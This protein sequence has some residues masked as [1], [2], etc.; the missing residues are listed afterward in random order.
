MGIRRYYFLVLLLVPILISI[1]SLVFGQELSIDELLLKGDNYYF[2]GKYQEALD[3]YSQAVD[4]DPK[5]DDA[6]YFAGDSL[7]MLKRYEEAISKFDQSIKINPASDAFFLKGKSHYMLEKY[8]EA[9]QNYEYSLDIFPDEPYVLAHY[10]IA[11]QKVGNTQKANETFIEANKLS[12]KIVELVA[13]E[14][15]Y[16]LTIKYDRLSVGPGGISISTERVKYQPFQAVSISGYV[17][18][19]SGNAYEDPKKVLI[20][21]YYT[22]NDKRADVKLVDESTVFSTY[23]YDVYEDPVSYYE[24]G[25]AV[26]EEGTYL[27][28]ATIDAY[29]SLEEIASTQIVVS[30]LAYSPV[31]V[32]LGIGVAGLGGLLFLIAKGLSI[33]PMI[34]ESLRFACITTIAVVPIGVFLTVD[35][36]VGQQSPLGLVIILNDNFVSEW[37]INIGG[38]WSD[39]YSGGIQI[40]VFVLLFGIAGGYIR[41]LHTIY[42]TLQTDETSW[43][44]SLKIVSDVLLKDI[45]RTLKNLENSEK[46]EDNTKIYK[47]LNKKLQLFQDEDSKLEEIRR[48]IFTQSIKDLALLFL[49]ALLAI[50]S[51]F[52]LIQAGIQSSDYATIAAVS[53]G[54]GLAT[55]TV[56]SRL[57]NFVGVAIGKEK[58]K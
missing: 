35:V 13:D 15:G 55:D 25:V 16:Q 56:I 7:Y 33:R 22:G 32:F 17:Y 54:V 53:F 37:V 42:K 1:P 49:S 19:E 34:R 39:Y 51:Y 14:L 40:P 12:P 18:D 4:L 27:I 31:A 47:E 43:K 20:K 21:T 26:L 29:T 5:N 52:L 45:K 10:G 23:Y 11:L 2:E 50:A 3:A 38:V 36:E 58:S 28:T 8:D 44:R 30:N 24:D 48:K 9:I 6:L 41:F 57:E 46:N